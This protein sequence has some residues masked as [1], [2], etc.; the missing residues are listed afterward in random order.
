MLAK[1]GLQIPLHRD[2]MATRSYMHVADAASAFDSILHHGE[3]RGVYNI[4]AQEERTIPEKAGAFRGAF[5][6]HLRWPTGPGGGPGDIGFQY[7]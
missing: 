6:E 2:G 4:G 3:D 7:F 1:R 5:T